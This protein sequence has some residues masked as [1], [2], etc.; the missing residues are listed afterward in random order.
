LEGSGKDYWSMDKY[1]LH[2]MAQKYQLISESENIKNYF[3][4]TKSNKV[5]L[6]VDERKRIIDELVK[7]DKFISSFAAIVLSIISLIVSVL[8]A[9]SK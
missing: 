3:I 9:V 5:N 8:V 6:D 2:T 4:K 7:R 1:E